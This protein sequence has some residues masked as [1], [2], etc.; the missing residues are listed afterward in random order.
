MHKKYQLLII[1]GGVSGTALLYMA[2][3]YSGLQNI[4][5]I[6]K[7]TELAQV[8]SHGGSNSQTMHCG[9]IETNYTLEKALVV[10]RAA[11]MIVNYSQTDGKEDKL[12]HNFSKMVLGVGAQECQQLRDRFNVFSEHY[13]AM[14]LL[15]ANDIARIEPNVALVNGE[16]RKD[17][18]VALGS[19]DEATAVDFGALA[20]S[21]VKSAQAVPGKDINLHL[22]DTVNSIE[23]KEGVYQVKTSEGIIEADAVVTCASGYSLLLAQKMGYGL[24]CSILPMGG[25]FYFT[26][27]V[28]NGKVY[29]VQNDKLPFAAVHGDPDLLVPGKTRFGPTAI[30]LPMLER[31]NIRSVPDLLR[32][33]RLDSD[34]FAVYKDLLGVK[35]IRHYLIKNLLFEVPVLRR[36]LFLKEV[37]KIVPSLKFEDVKFANR[38]GGLRPQLIDKNTRELKLGE[39]KIAPGDGLIF[40]LTP[41]PGGTSCL[42]NAEMD[43]KTICEYLNVPFFG[44]ESLLNAET[45]ATAA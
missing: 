43:L 19:E 28:L 31:Y 30:V 6:E 3:K 34:V 8:N 29:T 1:G 18:I 9:D 35:D 27:E 12:V 23:K 16:K 25:S 7:H 24:D 17:E 20:R 4:G 41:S 10:K 45:T 37:Q 11:D 21:F 39:G 42:Q 13:P 15:E 33:L 2:T 14:R 5:L 22:G 32:V 40:N 36:W 26:P 44:D 38:I